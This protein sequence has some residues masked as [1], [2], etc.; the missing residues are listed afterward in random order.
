MRIVRQPTY[1]VAVF[2]AAYLHSLEGNLEGPLATLLALTACDDDSTGPV[3]L[4]P[5][6]NVQAVATGPTSVRVSWNQVAEADSYEIDRAEDGGSF[7]SLQ[8]GLTATLF[9]DSGLAEGAE[10]R[11]RV[12]AVRGGDFSAHSAEISVETGTSAPRVRVIHGVTQDMTLQS[13]TT[14]VL[15]GF[16]KVANGATLT[17]EPGTI[18]RGTAGCFRSPFSAAWRS[19]MPQSVRGRPSARPP[20]CCRS[21]VPEPRARCPRCRGANPEPPENRSRRCRWWP[22]GRLT[23]DGMPGRF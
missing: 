2:G 5:P 14:Y 13:D 23:S 10:Y 4:S 9:E 8:T 19:G 3:N 6:A 17:I 21:P 1:L 15:S 11:Y 22:R 20:G 16:V 12:R 7:A 18:I